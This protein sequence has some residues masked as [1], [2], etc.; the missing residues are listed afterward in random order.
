MKPKFLNGRDMYKLTTIPSFLIPSLYTGS[1]KFKFCTPKKCMKQ[2]AAQF[3]DV[4]GQ[5]LADIFKRRKME[6]LPRQALLLS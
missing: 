6:G 1:W 4:E 5:E 2:E 3:G